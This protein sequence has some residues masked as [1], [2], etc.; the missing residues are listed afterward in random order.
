MNTQLGLSLNAIPPLADQFDPS[1]R[2]LL[3][4]EDV[5]KACA[6]LPHGTFQLILTSPP[7]NLGKA[8]ETQ[9]SLSAYLEWQEMVIQQ[10]IP[11]LKPGGSI[12]WQVGNF[13]DDGEI[14]P[15]DTLFY[16]IFKKYG[17]KLRNRIVW[18][19]NHRLHA[20]Y[21]FSGRYETLLW[22]TKGDQYLFNL[23]AV[24]VPSKYPGKT[25]YK[26]DKRGQPSGNPLGK[27]PSDLWQFMAEEWEN[28]IWEIP[29]VKSNH[30][31]KTEHPCQYPVEL[32][33]RCLLAF[34][35][36]DDWML[37]PFSGVGSSLIAG[38]KHQRR[39]VGIDNNDA[40][41]EITRERIAAF[42][43][44]T[45]KLRPLGKPV[46]EPTGR[47]QVTQRPKEWDTDKDREE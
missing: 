20:T 1:Q 3:I 32:A 13:V 16:P 11:L 42:H 40:Y 25:H 10:L 29:N 38:L 26:G 6:G 7:Y 43:Q 35:N 5:L 4:H 2:T 44:G 27:N 14:F 9:K 46:H 41:C 17:L 45:L 8:Y 36:P 15:L 30:P 39:V 12:C 28:G 21:R 47:E 31:E 37:D 22:F 33:E 24:R 18:H 34:T 23:D 19:F